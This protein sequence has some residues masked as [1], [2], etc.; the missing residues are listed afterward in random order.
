MTMTE[1][2]V[3]E[4]ATAVLEEAASRAG[5]SL[6]L[7]ND[8]DLLEHFDSM[9]FLEILCAIEEKLGIDVD[10]SDLEP[11]T[12]TRFAGLVGALRAHLGGA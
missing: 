8:T 7:T 10:F 9:T 5:I 1:D 4:V 11:E 12:Y 6:V 2:R 3:R